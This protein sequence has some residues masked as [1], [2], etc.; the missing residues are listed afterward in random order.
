VQI[1]ALAT[2]PTSPQI[3]LTPHKVGPILGAEGTR[4]CLLSLV[5][6]KTGYLVLGKLRARTTAEVNR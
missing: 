6:R 5:E 2:C 4:P 3:R 1:L